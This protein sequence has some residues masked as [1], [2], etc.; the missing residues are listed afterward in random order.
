MTT[1]QPAIWPASSGDLETVTALLTEAFLVS[2]IGDWLIP[3]LDTRE[4]VYSAYFRLHAEQALKTGTVDMTSD[5]TGVAVWYPD[6]ATA[7]GPDYTERLAAACGV[8][9]RRFELIDVI[10]AEHHPV[11]AHHY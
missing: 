11:V 9:L 5:G 4:H 7:T 10:F 6:P 2:P 1:T 3:D 8:W